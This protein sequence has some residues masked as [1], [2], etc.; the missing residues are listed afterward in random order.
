MNSLKH[1]AIQLLS[2]LPDNINIDEMMYRLYILDN[3]RNA[4]I[5]EKQG[6]ILSHK[7]VKQA[8]S[9]W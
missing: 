7:K 1:E 8:M 5:E 4:E 2:T 3:I 6:K 9:K